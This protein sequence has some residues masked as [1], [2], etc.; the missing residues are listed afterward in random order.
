[1]K[2]QKM[3]GSK[4]HIAKS[5]VLHIGLALYGNSGDAAKPSWL[6]PSHRNHKVLMTGAL[7]LQS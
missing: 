4:Y 5:E 3:I 2:S 1:M 6:S 7:L